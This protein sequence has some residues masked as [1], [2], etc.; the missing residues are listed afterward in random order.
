MINNLFQLLAISHLEGGSYNVNSILKA[1][2][3][4]KEMTLNAD[5]N[6]T[7]RFKSG[8]NIIQVL[9]GSGSLNINFYPCY[10]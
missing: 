10:L 7:I 1:K 6:N 3:N 5:K 9:E 4:D 8:E 2:V